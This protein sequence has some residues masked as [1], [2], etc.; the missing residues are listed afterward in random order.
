MLL[1]EW[2][3]QR[4]ET[5]YRYVGDTWGESDECTTAAVWAETVQEIG[6]DGPSYEVRGDDVYYMGEMVLQ[7]VSLAYQWAYPFAWLEH[8]IEDMSAEELRILIPKLIID[9]DQIQDIFQ[10][11]MSEDGYFD[12]QPV[13]D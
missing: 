13:I 2:L 10:E 4:P 12:L 9:N 6:Y 5:I 11:E 1:S 3:N 7:E 8:H